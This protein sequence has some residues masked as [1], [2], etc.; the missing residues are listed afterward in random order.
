MWSKGSQND[1]L[2]Y[3]A[4]RRSDAVLAWDMRMLTG[5][6]THP[7][8]GIAAYSRDSD[9]NQRLEFD[10]DDDGKRLFVASQ[11]RSVKIFDTSS[12]DLLNTIDGFRDA[13]NGISYSKV[14]GRELLAMATG[15][16]RFEDNDDN[17]DTA[18]EGSGRHYQSM[19]ENKACPTSDPPGSLELFEI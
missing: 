19:V 4:S 3:S 11:D 18:V 15:A 12:G 8:R 5:D 9:T 16:R 10:I 13:V 6:A 7:I 17:S 2:L 1:Y 14:N